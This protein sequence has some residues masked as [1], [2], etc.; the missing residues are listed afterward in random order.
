MIF[1]QERK[2]TLFSEKNKHKNYLLFYAIDYT[3]W[4]MNFAVSREVGKITVSLLK[5]AS[6]I[7]S[8][9]NLTPRLICRFVF[10]PLRL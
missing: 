3:R 6:L 9:L 10:C 1:F 4:G 5:S 2:F 8:F 7:V